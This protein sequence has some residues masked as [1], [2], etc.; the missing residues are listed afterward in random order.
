M[1]FHST[2]GQCLTDLTP[3][4]AERLGVTHDS[5]REV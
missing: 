4:Q 5:K 2:L 1:E 3:E